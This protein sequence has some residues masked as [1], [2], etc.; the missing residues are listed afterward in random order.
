MNPELRSRRAL[1]VQAAAALFL[2]A[3]VSAVGDFYH[4]HTGTIVYTDPGVWNYIS[5]SQ[6]L[7]HQIWRQTFVIIPFFFSVSA[8]ML[9]IYA[10]TAR[11]LAKS[12]SRVR[13]TSG[14]A[15]RDAVE[16][17][18][19]FMSMYFLSAFAN[20]E[21]LFLFIAFSFMF[22][23]R[24]TATYERGFI[25]VV[26]LLCGLAGAF[27]EGTICQVPYHDTG[28]FG[29]PWWLAPLYMN[30]A[31]SARALIRFILYRGA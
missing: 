17:F 2:V 1:M 4:I 5:P 19:T 16:P 13:S 14:A 12:V 20:D 9:A 8:G 6:P 26:A 29:S 25:L 7:I 27:Y 24:L 28:L 18:V 11:L 10:L 15:F 22:V 23:V 30:G 3:C 21:P 31:L